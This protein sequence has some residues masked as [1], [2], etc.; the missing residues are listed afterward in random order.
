MKEGVM[1]VAIATAI[2]GAALV[3]SPLAQPSTGAR[4]SDS[5][6][7]PFTP[8]GRIRMDLSAGDYEIAGSKDRRIHIE[9]SVREASQLPRV[10]ARVDVRGS[11]ASIE[12]EGPSNNSGLRFVIQVPDRSDLYVRLT[13]GDI[14]IENVRGNKDVEMHAGDMRIDV[15]RIDDYQRVD[16]SLWAGDIHAAPFNVIKGGLFRSFDWSGKGPYRLHAK[17]KAGDLR[18]YTKG[19][20]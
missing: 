18:L 16:G 8:E 1:R 17:L 9:W 6:E 3:A 2:L 4:P 12:T 5:L 15:G 13:A 19:A 14:R 11:D 10:H 20:L 7:R